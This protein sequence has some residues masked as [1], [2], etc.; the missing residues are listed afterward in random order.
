VSA[1]GPLTIER[2]LGAQA[3][4]Y[5]V[6]GLWPLVHYRSFERVTGPKREAWLVKTVG[7]L[8]LT[9]AAA[10]SL[11]LRRGTVPPE[12]R[13]VGAGTAATLAAI[14]VTYRRRG[15]LNWAYAVDAVA[16]GALVLGAA[17]SPESRR[18]GDA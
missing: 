11:A 14:D 7:G 10:N 12:V 9:V 4:Y 15:R 6:G 8:L 16:Q 17:L 1:D 18:G 3:A 13:L 2:V 5:L